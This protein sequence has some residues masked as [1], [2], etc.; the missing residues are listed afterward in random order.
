MTNFSNLEQSLFTGFINKNIISSQD[1]RPHLL[2]NDYKRGKKVLTTI[3][4][5]LE[6]CEE[7][8]FSVAFVTTS[9]LAVLMNSLILLEKKKYQR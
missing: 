5:D 6:S 7:F 2:I 8:W 9:G 3:K 1:F 4:R